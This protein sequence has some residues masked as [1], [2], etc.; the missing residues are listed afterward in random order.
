MWKLTEI[1]SDK[2]YRLALV[3]AEN[4]SRTF[5]LHDNGE[6]INSSIKVLLTEVVPSELLVKRSL[7]NISDSV[8]LVGGERFYVDA[9]GIWLTEAEMKAITEDK[10]DDE[11]PWLNGMAPNFAPR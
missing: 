7:K 11:I 9:H 2:T 6:G 1:Q 4:G 10:E 5:Q 8:P 3:Q